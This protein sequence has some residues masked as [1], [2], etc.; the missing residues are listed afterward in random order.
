MRPGVGARIVV[1]GR[2]AGWPDRECEVVRGPF[3]ERGGHS[4]ALRTPPPVHQ[5][6]RSRSILC[7]DLSPIC[8]I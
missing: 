2:G 6:G 8:P 7:F 5:M 4:I 3:G 1:G